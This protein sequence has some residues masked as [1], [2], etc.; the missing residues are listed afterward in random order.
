MKLK[1]KYIEETMRKLLHLMADCASPVS[2]TLEQIKGRS[3]HIKEDRGDACVRKM[4]WRK[5]IG[6]LVLS[7][8]FFAGE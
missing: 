8:L 2:H 3:K 7:S 5:M 6:I 4:A 1:Q